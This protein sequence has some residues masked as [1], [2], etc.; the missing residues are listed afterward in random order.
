MKAHL[1]ILAISI[2]SFASLL[3]QNNVGINTDNPNPKAALDIA[4]SGLSKQGLLIPKFIESDT[5]LF[6]AGLAD[7]GLMFYDSLGSQFMYWNGLKWLSIGNKVKVNSGSVDGEVLIWDGSEWVVSPSIIISG[8][9]LGIGTNN[10]QYNLDVNGS[11]RSIDLKDALSTA[12]DSGLVYVDGEGLLKVLEYDNNTTRF[13]RSDGQWANTP[14]SPWS[15]NAGEVYRNTG[16]VGIGNSD[17]EEKLHVSYGGADGAIRVMQ[18]GLS[19]GDYVG[20]E[21]G[22]G[23]GQASASTPKTGIYWVDNY[24]FARGDLYFA[25]NY[26]ND[27]TT[28]VTPADVKMVLSGNN[29][30]LGIGTTDPL[31]RL[32]LDFDEAAGGITINNSRTTGSGG[33]GRILFQKQ[34]NPEWVIGFDAS[35]AD[36]FKF[37]TGN[38]IGTND[39]FTIATNG[40]VGIGTSDPTYTL[41]VE[42]TMG[43]DEYLFHNGD[44]KTN[45]RFTVGNTQIGAVKND[46]FAL[47][48]LIET[49]E[50][51]KVVLGYDI[52]TRSLNAGSVTDEFGTGMSFKLNDPGDDMY[53]TSRIISTWND[54]GNQQAKLSFWVRK[55]G[56][57]NEIY[58]YMSLSEGGELKLNAYNGASQR[59]LV[60]ESDGRV[61]IGSSNVGD[62]TNVTAGNGLT[63]GGA[64]G[65]VTLTANVGNGLQI[66]TD[67]IRLGGS[68]SGATTINL[69]GNNFDINLDGS[70]EFAIQDAGADRFMVHDNGNVSIGTSGTAYTSGASYYLTVTTPAGYANTSSASLE[71]KGNV[72]S[73]NT[74]A[75]RVDLLNGLTAT[76]IGRVE[77][78]TNGGSTVQGHLAFS[79]NNGTLTER[80]RIEDGGD[81]G[82]GIAS[83]NEKVQIYGTNA[84]TDGT[85]GVT[86]QISNTTA[87]SGSTASL[88]FVTNGSLTSRGKTGVIHEDNGS[89]G[90]GKL[91]LAATQTTTLGYKVGVPDA[92]LTVLNNGNI[93]IGTTNPDHFLAVEFEPPTNNIVPL[94]VFRKTGATSSAAPIRFENT[95]SNHFNIGITADNRFSM[96]YN[97]NIGQAS[98]KFTLDAVG[99]VAIGGN[100]ASTQ[101]KLHIQNG[102][103]AFD[104]TSSYGIKWVNGNTLLAHIHRWNSNERLYV[105]NA[106]NSNLTGVYLAPSA[107]SWTSN[108]DRRMKENIIN[109]KYGLEDVL[110]LSVKE[111]NFRYSSQSNRKLGFIAQE[112]FE[113]FPEL[114]QKGDDSDFTGP[115]DEASVKKSGFESWGLD[116]DGFGVLAIKA[117]QEQQKIIED[118]KKRIEELEKK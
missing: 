91:H 30:N 95:A 114:V 44:S 87:T 59:N 92:R 94:A 24:T 111:Y 4:P 104:P 56:G 80:M 97:N 71:I 53:E 8:D 57:A 12:N 62:I 75:A 29:G 40:R 43:I 82:I 5:A 15:L 65:S 54:P 49:E 13:L 52:Y 58:E 69:G 74:Q 110:K 84:T 86:V 101:A 107:T 31:D 9:S 18:N 117:I 7:K 51:N 6:S 55:S 103:L 113:V 2:F 38:T 33:N 99:R 83:P 79:T 1:L 60:I 105:T 77:A 25:I 32:V 68:L 16:N 78:I 20:I 50:F 96:N 100:F 98:D 81:V 46:D 116:Y 90:I 45:L 47:S 39:R 109:T 89:N 36:K 102:D 115:F 64:S 3:A 76:T 72:N 108:S 112:V 22:G 14:S 10:P 67:Q 63:G 106:G 42:G 34:S 88:T 41:D 61:G 73:S 28:K 118:L 35:D 23:E 11:I 93:G 27:Y 85:D 66:M 48:T 21:L 37:S 19:T 26:D 17:P 70:G